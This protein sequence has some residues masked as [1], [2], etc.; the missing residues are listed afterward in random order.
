MSDRTRL[1]RER[2]L[3]RTVAVSLGVVV[4]GIVLLL[5]S[6]SLQVDSV[7]HSITR[8]LGSLMVATVCVALLWELAAKRSLLSELLAVTQLA[9]RI[10]RTGVVGLADH[11]YN[12]IPWSR[13][14]GATEDVDIFLAYG[15]SWRGVL[16][17]EIAR[18]GARSGTRCRVVLPDPDDPIV[19]AAVACQFGKTPDLIRERVLAAKN[20][21]LANLGSAQLEVWYSK[22]P[23]LF[24]FYL[25]GNSAVVTLY[26]HRSEPSNTIGLVCRRDGTFFE[27]LRKEFD[28][29][30]GPASG[31]RR[32]HPL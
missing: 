12:D 2:T 15:V 25:M 16:G 18:F 28:S 20:D 5:T 8:D 30:V 7:W 17:E 11:W 10:E 27:F 14:F 6:R 19:V 29:F 24:S 23:P 26:K 1:Y 21:F 32:A 13:L 22:R 9:E 31:A 3:L 4:L